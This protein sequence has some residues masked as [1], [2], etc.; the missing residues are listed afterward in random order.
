MAERAITLATARATFAE[1]RRAV[2]IT[3]V[4]GQQAVELARVHTYHETGRLISEYLLFNGER[5]EYGANT[6]QLLSDDLKIDRSVLGRCVKFYRAFP[7]WATWPKLTWAHFRELIP[8]SAAKVRRT[9]ATEANRNEWPVARLAR[10]IRELA[11]AEEPEVV[12]LPA[13]GTP[14]KL[15]SPKRG[16][17]GVC[18]V[19]AVGEAAVVDLGF[20]CYLD[21]PA[22]TKM[23]AGA[24]VRLDAAGRIAPAPAAGKADLFTYPAAVLKVVDGDTL[25]VKVY[26]RPGHWVKQKLRLRDLDCPEMAT[27]EGR[28]AKR[29][30][31]AFLDRAPAVIIC[32]TKPDKYDRYL[33]DVFVE[34]DGE[35]RFLNNALLENGHAVRKAS[36]EFRDW[37]KELLG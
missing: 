21:L 16:A 32:T 33:A 22:S 31:A 36:W 7:I 19:I 3:T 28:A 24:F 15:L 4:K 12:A 26:L 18:K 35:Q 23:K 17:P 11:P 9:L 34:R 13:P 2:E 30:T 27:A 10:R 25:W 20:A 14:V 29:F 8:I 5:A 1:L 37:E 6:I